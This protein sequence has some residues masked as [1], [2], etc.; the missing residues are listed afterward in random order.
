MLQFKVVNIID[1]LNLIPGTL[2]KGIDNSLPHRSKLDVNGWNN[3]NTGTYAI[4]LYP[5][6]I[7][8]KYK[9]VSYFTTSVNERIAEFKDYIST[10]EPWSH[11]KMYEV[12]WIKIGNPVGLFLGEIFVAQ[13]TYNGGVTVLMK[14]LILKEV[15]WVLLQINESAEHADIY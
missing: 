2:I 9:R 8:S 15:G 12:V 1:I 3:P 10:N 13:N 7:I 11:K 4:R 6:N 5:G 14:M